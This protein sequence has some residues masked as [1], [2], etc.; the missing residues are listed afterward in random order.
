VAL[1][2][3]GLGASQSGATFLAEMSVRWPDVGRV[4]MTGAASIDHVPEVP[5]A[6]FVRKPFLLDDVVRALSVAAGG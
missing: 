4:L 1:I 3:E 2:D 5:C 6:A